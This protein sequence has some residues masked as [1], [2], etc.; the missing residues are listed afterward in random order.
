MTR[1]RLVLDTNQIIAAGSRW[2][3]A[4]QPPAKAAQRFVYDAFHRHTGLYSSQIMAEYVEKLLDKNHP[5]QRITEY[6][7]CILALGEKIVVVRQDCDPRP[8]DA[9]DVKFVLCALDGEA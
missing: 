1:F 5:P 4:P 3:E 6:I 7:G 2:L 8:S 9:D